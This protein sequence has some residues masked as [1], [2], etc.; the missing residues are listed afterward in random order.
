MII[1]CN[2]LFIC[3]NYLYSTLYSTINY[4]LF[5]PRRKLH[6]EVKD[7]ELSF[8][9]R[10]SLQTLLASIIAMTAQQTWKSI[11]IVVS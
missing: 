7:L 4:H 2:L 3:D 8:G 9:H 1:R 11:N 5:L 6:A 10:I